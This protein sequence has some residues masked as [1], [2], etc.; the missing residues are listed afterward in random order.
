MRLDWIRT[1]T[2]GL[3]FMVISLVWAVYNAFVPVFYD[4]F[5]ESGT[6]I[7]LLMITDN[8]IG[9]TLQ[10]WIA[11]KSDHTWTR[12][13]RRM[14]FIL[15]GAPV[16]ALLFALIPYHTNLWLLLFTALGMNLAMGLYRAPT[17]ALMPDIT[18]RPLRSQANGI[19]NLMGGLGALLAFFAA[20][21]LYRRDPHLPFLLTAVIV[22]LTVAALYWKIKEPRHLAG[23]QET[24]ELPFTEAVRSVFQL[25]RRD[26][27]Y[28]LLAI[29]A[30][31]VGYQGLEAFFTLYGINVLGIDE[32]A[33]AMTLGFFALSF[34]IFAVPAGFLAGRIGRRN[35]IR[36]GLVLLL[37][38]FVV[39]FSVRSLVVIQALF[40]LG[41]LSWALINVNSYPMVVEMASDTETGTYTG[42]YYFFSSGA[43]IAGPPLMGVLRDLFGYEYLF[44]YAVVP[45]ALAFLLM[46]KVRGGEAVIPKG[47]E[48]GVVSD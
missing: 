36:T 14:P 42:L 21:P 38:V 17:V 20:A 39:A 37:L 6:I 10:P 46:G 30:W 34:L 26:T 1:F 33:G 43:A 3:G 9:I 18:P 47:V 13:G 31:F 4:R 12:F 8:I 22:L 41:G 24:K 28:L 5:I 44:L 11:H 40:L 32:A 16:A 19:I 2:L 35:T 48:T 23:E 7:G 25:S 29:F 45:V 27:L 15:I